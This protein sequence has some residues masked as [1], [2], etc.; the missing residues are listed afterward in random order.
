MTPVEN[1]YENELFGY[2]IKS[3]TQDARSKKAYWS[4][5]IGLNRVDGL[6]PSGYLIELAE[7]HIE[8]AMTSDEVDRR[9]EGYYSQK[10]PGTNDREKECDLVS[11]RIVDLLDQGGFTFSVQ[12]LKNIHGYLFKDLLFDRDGKRRNEWAEEFRDANFTK[13]EAVLGGDTVNHANFFM[14]EDTLKY[15]FEQEKG[16]RYAEPIDE[17]QIAHIARFASSIWQVH[18]FRE[19]NTHTTAVFLELYLRTLGFDVDNDLLKEHSAYFRN[20]LVRSNYANVRKGVSPDFSYLERF[21]SNLLTGTEHPL[22]TRDLFIDEDSLAE[23]LQDLR[24]MG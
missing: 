9:L 12:M 21:F 14:V 17:G 19:G 23:Y 20:A 1:R 8:G 22:K 11:K 18:G 10:E 13:R 4:A 7:Q 5:A 24:E 16:H 6:E 15:D 2:Q 3:E